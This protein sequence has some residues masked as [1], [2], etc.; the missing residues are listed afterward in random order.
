M[1][2]HHNVFAATLLVIGIVFLCTRR[3]TGLL[4]QASIYGAKG[5]QGVV[6]NG[7]LNGNELN[8]APHSTAASVPSGSS[9]ASAADEQSFVDSGKHTGSSSEEGQP[10]EA[11]SGKPAAQ[12]PLPHQESGEDSSGSKPEYMFQNDLSLDLPVSVLQ[13]FST[14]TPL[15]YEADKSKPYAF[16]TF[17]ATRNPSLKDPYF[18]AI[19]S[20]IHRIL[21]SPRTRT[22]KKYPF[23]VFVAEFVTPEQRALLAGAGAVVREL[24]PLEWHCDSSGVQKRWN[25]LFAKLNMWA[26]T[27][28]ER[29]LFLDADAFPLANIDEMLDSAPVQNCVENRVA[30]DDFLPDQSSVCEAYVFAG[31]PQD[32]F[33]VEMPNINVGSM[34]FKPSMRMHQ[35]L[36][37]N[38]QKTDHYDCAMAEQAF[39]NWQFSPGSAYPPT[40]LQRQWGGFFPKDE[41]EGKLKV[42]HEK[43]WAEGD[44]WLRKEWE[45]GWTEM[46]MW[47]GSEE[48]V[49]ARK[50]GGP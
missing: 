38:Y 6:N 21:W 13:Q 50:K 16:G 35:R 18:L 19:H 26:E 2:R 22:Q 45:R 7:H 4:D 33:S 28:F 30:L 15:N 12:S 31:V 17:M 46:T 23:I 25:D 32:S 39:L 24:S 27:D 49:E 10:L 40:R 29:I 41:D 20:L 5:A 9:L 8:T 47:Y 44:G 1:R 36:L 14:H 48:F 11:E 3:E 34:V 43:L 42:V 37:Q